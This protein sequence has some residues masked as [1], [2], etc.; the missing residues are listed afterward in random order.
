MNDTS[1]GQILGVNKRWY[2][3]LPCNSALSGEY[4][5]TVLVAGAIGDYAAYTGLGES[6]GLIAQFGDKISFEEAC[7]HFP[8]G[9]E[10]SKYR[11]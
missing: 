4:V 9:L 6:V 5:T 7:V 2:G 3:H 8:S 10:R 1:K 11:D